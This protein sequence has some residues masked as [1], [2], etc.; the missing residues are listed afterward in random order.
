MIFSLFHPIHIITGPN[1]KIHLK[2][3]RNISYISEKCIF[4]IPTQNIK[5]KI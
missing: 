1:I 5:Q 4:S 3:N 2:N